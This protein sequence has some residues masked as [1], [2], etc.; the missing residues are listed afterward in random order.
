MTSLTEAH[1]LLA[2][3]VARLEQAASNGHRIGDDAEAEIAA[4]R[5][6]CR[7]LESRNAEVSSRLDAAIARLRATLSE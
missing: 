3:A 6:R 7:M 4:L 1:D 5:E 2:K